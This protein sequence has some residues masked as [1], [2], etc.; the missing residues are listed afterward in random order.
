ML[1]LSHQ[2][3]ED[4]SAQLQ[5]G[6]AVSGLSTA[7]PMESTVSENHKPRNSRAA[8]VKELVNS[9]LSCF[10][11]VTIVCNILPFHLLYKIQEKIEAA[12][13]TPTAPRPV[14]IWS[15]FSDVGVDRVVLLD[16]DGG[17]DVCTLQTQNTLR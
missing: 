6:L 2:A 7:L 12:V 5:S 15:V 11:A 1:E 3:Q 14:P 17:E 10:G 13:T 9:M 4:T 8:A 16:S